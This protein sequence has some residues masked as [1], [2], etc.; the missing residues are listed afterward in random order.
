MTDLIS[1]AK[2]LTSFGTFKPVGHLM[3]GLPAPVALPALEAA[4]T[5]AGWPGDSLLHFAPG[6][7]VA[8]LETMVGDAGAMA[9]FGYEITLLHRYL[10][11]SREGYRWLL[12]KVDGNNQAVAAADL[13]RAHGAGLAV[14][15]RTLVTEELI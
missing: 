8:D 5:A 13:A 11:L 14:Y 7:S 3:L 1:P 2:V 9:G 10:A 6:R 12:V 15:Y 4:L